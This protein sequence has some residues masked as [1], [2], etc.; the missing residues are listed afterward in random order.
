MPAKAGIQ[1]S[2]ESNFTAKPVDTGSSAF[3]E[4]DNP[5][6]SPELF[7]WLSLFLKMAVT[8]CFVVVAA[9]VAERAGAM[10][11]AIVAT[12]PIAAGPAYFFVAQDHDAA[13]ISASA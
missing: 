8:A 11:G 9:M 1:Y 5:A 6:M 13:F 3:A 2:P 12:L 7:F 10:I 4:D